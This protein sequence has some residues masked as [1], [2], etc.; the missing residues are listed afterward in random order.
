MKKERIEYL[1]IL[2]GIGIFL[3]VYE[4]VSMLPKNSVLGNI[5]MCMSYGAVPCFM[6]VTGGLMHQR[7]E[8][9]W[10]KYLLRL[11]KMYL[12]LCFWKAAYLLFYKSL[13][14]LSFSK[15]DLFSYL[16]LFGTLPDVNAGLLW[17]LEAYLAVMLLYPVTLFLFRGGRNG[18]ITLLFWGGIVSLG[19]LAVIAG[20]HFE[21]ANIEAAAP[22]MTYGNMFFYFIAGAFFLE[23]RE[24]IR[25]FLGR[26]RWRKFVPAVLLLAGTFGLMILKFLKTGT[27]CWE[28]LHVSNSY[29]RISTVFLAAGIYLF[30][31]LSDSHRNPAGR[32]IGTFLGKTT[33]GIYVLHGILVPCV[34]IYFS[35][36]FQGNESLVLHL[37]VTVF[38]VIICA[39]VTKIL[40]K[41]PVL[42]ALV[43]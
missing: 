22:F 15:K 42:R 38:T 25:D 37:A 21:G 7:N 1:D 29:Y 33:M 32:F 43:L 18:R 30:V 40:R 4:H 8:L 6:M 17:Y 24:M 9:D 27:F 3:V 16:F 2:K 13:Y 39:A 14:A 28:Q 36:Y 23:E 12:L 41:I 10:Q 34:Q 20:R 31:M 11:I 35:K 5:L 26:K 19:S